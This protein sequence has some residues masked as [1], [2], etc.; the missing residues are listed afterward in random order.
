MKAYKG[1]RGIAPFILNIGA[2]WRK[3]VNIAAWL[4]HPQQRTLI[5]TEQKA[6]WAP[7]VGMNYLEKRRISC[8]CGDSSPGPSSPLYPIYYSNYTI[9]A[10]SNT[11]C[12]Y[13][14]GYITGTGY[15]SDLFPPE[16]PWPYQNRI[17]ICFWA[18]KDRPCEWRVAWQPEARPL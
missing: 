5:P 11:V 6:R 1:S 15:I 12:E 14:L 3:V 9:P 17:F 4:L 2:R 7:R 13:N 8:P 18:S 16:K 10:L